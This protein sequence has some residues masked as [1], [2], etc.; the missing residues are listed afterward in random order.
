MLVFDVAGAVS[1][2]ARILRHA[3][4]NVYRVQIFKYSVCTKKN[5][6]HSSVFG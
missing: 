6:R 4:Q 3:I 2:Y 5:A 1:S